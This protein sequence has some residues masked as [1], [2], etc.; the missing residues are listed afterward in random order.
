MFDL[1][2]MGSRMWQGLLQP[3]QNPSV[4]SVQRAYKDRRT[5]DV[6]DMGWREMRSG[7]V[8]TIQQRGALTTTPLRSGHLRTIR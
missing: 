1:M 2:G 5:F 4:G 3:L 6:V 8:V 7:A